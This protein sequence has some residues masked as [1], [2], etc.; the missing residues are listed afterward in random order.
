MRGV[1]QPSLRS[2]AVSPLADRRSP[3]GMASARTNALTYFTSGSN[4]GMSDGREL[5]MEIVFR[6]HGGGTQ[7]VMATGT[8]GDT[9]WQIRNSS[10][11]HSIRWNLENDAGVQGFNETTANLLSQGTDYQII[12]SCNIAAGTN[13]AQ[14]AI[15]SSDS[16]HS[17]TITD[18]LIDFTAFTNWGIFATTSGGGILNADIYRILMHDGYLDLASNVST[19]WDAA[20]GKPQDYGSDGS[21]LL[22]VQPALYMCLNYQTLSDWD[23]GI[24]LG[25]GSNLSR[26]GPAFGIGDS[27]FA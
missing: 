4:F 24:N 25:S 23:S 5:T 2:A 10:P 1:L 15:N 8:P 16:G 14:I 21:G 3:A 22:G 9:Y 26:Q 19:F 18:T 13:D 6:L 17:F 7:N 20:E 27:L 12:M 11:P